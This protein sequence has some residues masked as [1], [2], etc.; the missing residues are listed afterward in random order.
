MHLPRNFHSKDTG[1]GALPKQ[2]S[3]L[4]KREMWVQE[5]WDPAEGRSKWHP[6]N[7]VK[8]DPR[9]RAMRLKREV[10]QISA[11]WLKKQTCEDCYHNHHPHPHPAPNHPA[12]NC[13]FYLHTKCSGEPDPD[14]YVYL[15]SPNHKLIEFLLSPDTQLPIPLWCLYPLRT[16]LLPCNG[17]GGLLWKAGVGTG[18]AEM[19]NREAFIP[20][21]YICQ[22]SKTRSIQQPCSDHSKP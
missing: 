18:N 12:F 19:G 6:Q 15:A 3:N 22:T 10:I 17:Y 8:N 14:S 16:F 13:L 1:G 9:T 11:M 21:P 4:R 2:K 7:T 5:A 20:F